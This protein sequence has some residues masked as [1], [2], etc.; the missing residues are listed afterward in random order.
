MKTLQVGIA[1]TGSIG[2]AYASW[3]ANK[4]HNVTVWSPRSSDANLFGTQQLFSTGVLE[5]SFDIV[6]A[7]TPAALAE[8]K[9]VIIIA[10]PLN[11][12]QAVMDALLPH[13]KSGCT[14]IVSAMASLSSLYLYEKALHRE[15]DIT[16]ASFGTTA[17]TARKQGPSLVNI[18]TRRRK[19]G[20]SCF[21]KS[22]IESALEIC[23]QLFDSEL[24]IDENPLLS[25]LSN[26]SAVGH[27][28]L[29]IFNWTRI[30]RA[31]Q[32]AQYHY[33]TPEVS[34]L[35]ELLDN[36]RRA[37]ALAFGW[38]VPSFSSKLSKNFG[39]KNSVL[40]DVASELHELRG[41]PAG[42]KDTSTR[43]IWED[44]PFGL[45][46]VLELGRI[47]KIPTPVTESLVRVSGFLLSEDLWR[48]NGFIEALCIP[49]TNVQDLLSRVS[50]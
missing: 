42:P 38:E 23:S 12:H 28:P 50:V 18:M 16:V 5:Q 21:P 7:L 10:V 43:Y 47:S 22:R 36:E 20:V 14:V 2:L 37:V 44:V 15:L 11:G 3:I 32:W 27:V 35:I 30:E 39:L 41:G 33:M 49:N 40:A 29:A 48:I 25:T 19:L 46:F 8:D 26:T 24:R 1:G 9:D 6:P 45:N 17:L 13:L 34:G 4:C 31:E